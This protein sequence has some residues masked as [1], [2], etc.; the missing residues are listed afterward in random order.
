MYVLAHVYV[1][2]TCM[3]WPA[4]VTMFVVCGAAGYLP[5]DP[6]YPDDRLAIYMEDA[7]ASIV[8]S[9]GSEMARACELAGGGCDVMDVPALLEQSTH[10][11]AG[12]PSRSRSSED[13]ACYIIFTSGSTGRPKGVVVKHRGVQD[14][15]PWLAELHQIG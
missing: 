13:G 1:L 11:G 10:R 14:L 4:L 12:N 7:G 5:C 2:A 9:Q 15:M 8:L 3:C 6:D